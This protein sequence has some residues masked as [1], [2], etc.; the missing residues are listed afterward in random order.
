MLAALAWIIELQS[1][2]IKAKHLRSLRWLILSGPQLFPPGK[3]TPSSA[4][5]IT[6]CALGTS[7]YHS[8]YFFFVSAG[9]GVGVGWGMAS[10]TQRSLSNFVVVFDAKVDNPPC[11]GSTY[12]P[13]QAFLSLRFKK[14]SGSFLRP[15]SSLSFSVGLKLQSPDLGGWTMHRA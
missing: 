14:T 6:R 7:F 9:A 15:V 8:W 11:N 13:P 12:V 3:T 1:P 10:K 2:H 4:S 5:A